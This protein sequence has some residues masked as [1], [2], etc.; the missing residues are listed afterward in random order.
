M[1]TFQMIGL[2]LIVSVNPSASGVPPTASTVVKVGSFKTTADCVSASK[3]AVFGNAST[4]SDVQKSVDFL[5]IPEASQRI[6]GV[7]NAGPPPLVVHRMN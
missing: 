1:Y 7:S 5:C 2:Y 4:G 6:W 3:A